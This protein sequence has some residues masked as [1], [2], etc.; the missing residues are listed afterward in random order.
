MTDKT[1]AAKGGRKIKAEV[2]KR[3]TDFD[4]NPHKVGAEVSLSKEHF[5]HFEKHGG[6]KKL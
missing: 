4:G 3:I 6:V 2:L 5:E 1:E